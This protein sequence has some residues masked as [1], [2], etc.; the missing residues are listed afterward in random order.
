M[1]NK[2]KRNHNYIKNKT[3]KNC[4]MVI[5]SYFFTFVD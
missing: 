1:G 4:F 2:D 3:A 5:R